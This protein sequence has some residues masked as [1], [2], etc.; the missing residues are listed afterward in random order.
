MQRQC[1]AA[2][3]HGQAGRPL[4]ALP[5][6]TP[7][8]ATIGFESRM[9]SPNLNSAPCMQHHWS[10]QTK[11]SSKTCSPPAQS[12]FNT[13]LPRP[14]LATPTSEA[15]PP[16]GTHPERVRRPRPPS[17]SVASGVSSGPVPL[18]RQEGIEG[19]RGLVP[20]TRRGGVCWTFAG[21][22]SAAAE[23]GWGP[24]RGREKAELASRFPA[25]FRPLTARI[26]AAIP[27]GRFRCTV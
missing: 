15:N 22:R 13:Q 9:P 17:R 6:R 8:L 11:F 27:L 18:L 14:E 12:R 26:F 3:S 2:S 20:T 1:S 4:T 10:T 21:R 19:T 5:N 16:P 7:L 23:A 24:G 25:R